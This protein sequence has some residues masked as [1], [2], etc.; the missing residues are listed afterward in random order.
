[1]PA[2]EAV[3]AANGSA[4]GSSKLGGKAVGKPGAVCRPAQVTPSTRISHGGSRS[5][6]HC[7]QPVCANVP[8]G[9][10]PALCWH[11]MSACSSLAQLTA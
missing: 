4:K 5:A 2:D 3:A 11:T 9:T 6:R 8:E 1:M 7:E 10:A